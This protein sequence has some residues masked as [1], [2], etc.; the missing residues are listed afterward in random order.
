MRQQKYHIIYKTTCKKTNK[1]YIGMHST[2]NL[3][4]GYQGSGLH[5][6]RSIKAYGKDEHTVEILEFCEDRE[7]LS[8]REAAILTK[9]VISMSSCMNLMSG[10]SGSWPGKI[11]PEAVRAKIS[12][13]TKGILKSKEHKEN[14][15]LARIGVSSSNKSK[16]AKT[17][18]ITASDGSERLISNLSNW[19]KFNKTVSYKKLS[20]GYSSEGFIAT[21]V[22]L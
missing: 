15:R 21:R 3:E 5:L 13:S 22:D 9:E 17:W 11:I 4:D 7:S 12:A 1:W 10:G 2:N 14:I 18:K 20:R 8:K 6:L 19:V 16:N